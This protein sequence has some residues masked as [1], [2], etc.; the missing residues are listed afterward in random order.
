MPV[1][2]DFML[3]VRS[4]ACRDCMAASPLVAQQPRKPTRRQ[5]KRTV[6]QQLTSFIVSATTMSSAPTP[7]KKVYLYADVG[8]G[9]RCVA[10]TLESLKQHLPLDLQAETIDSDQLLLGGWQKEC[11]LLVMPG[12]ADL[13]YCRL[14]NGPGNRLIKGDSFVNRQRCVPPNNVN[15]YIGGISQLP[16][17]T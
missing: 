12:G 14:L 13:P 9:A 1:F 17:L 2:A 10:S 16:Q 5:P 7:R 15:N 11:A 4:P 6:A 3:S 8:A